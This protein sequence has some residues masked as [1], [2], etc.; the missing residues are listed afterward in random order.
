MLADFEVEYEL[1]SKGKKDVPKE[2]STEQPKQIQK[3]K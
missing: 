2:V 1:K 3:R